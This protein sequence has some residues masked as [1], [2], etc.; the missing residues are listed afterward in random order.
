VLETGIEVL[1][2]APLESDRLSLQRILNRSQSRVHCFPTC[3]AALAF[4]RE[5]PLGVVIANAELPDSRWQDLIEA[6]SC[7]AHPPHVIVSSRLADDGFWAEVLNLGG[8]DVLLTPFDREEVLRVAN[9][10][11]LAWQ[12]RRMEVSP[13]RKAARSAAT[14]AA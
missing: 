10:A 5:H 8:Y 11:W 13:V 7:L 6:M 14:V 1:L 2:I 3:K 4:L 12:R 9:L